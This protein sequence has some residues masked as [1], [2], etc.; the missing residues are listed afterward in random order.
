MGTM[1]SL[2][3]PPA[4][5][6]HSQHPAIQLP[7]HNHPKGLLAEL[8]AVERGRCP[9]MDT[10]GLQGHLVAPVGGISDLEH[11]SSGVVR[12]LVGR[13]PPLRTRHSSPLQGSEGQ[14]RS[15]R[16]HTA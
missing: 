11:E 1:R 10:R 8:H 9:A 6:S 13:Q 12:P 14:F 2:P 4:Q 3:D 15:A 7:A 16:P 5:V